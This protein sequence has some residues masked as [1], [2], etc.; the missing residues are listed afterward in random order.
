M[1][2][3]KCTELVVKYFLL[4]DILLLGVV[5]DLDTHILPG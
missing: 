4:A 1:V 2:C 5:L 3:T